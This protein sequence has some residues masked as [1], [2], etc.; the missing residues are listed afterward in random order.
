V[1]DG[2]HLTV[3]GFYRLVGIVLDVVHAAGTSPSS[4]AE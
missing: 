4:T 3:I 2:R 1:P